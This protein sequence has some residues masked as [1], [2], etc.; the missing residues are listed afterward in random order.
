MRKALKLFHTL[1]SCGLIGALL[2]YTIVLIHAPQAS[3]PAYA[4]ARQVISMLCNFL[5]LPSLAVALV[6]GL[7]SMVVHRPFQDTRWAWLKAVL[8]LSMFEATLG[9]VQSKATTAAVESAKA[10]TGAAE[11]GALADA[12]ANEWAAL[13]V[14]MALS[15]AQ[16]GLGVWRPRL[17]KR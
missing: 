13:A 9:I 17:A 10:V 15:I 14:I 16:V 3:P 11:P 12:L 2:G 4:Q 1:A 5:L 8:G 6:T 7:F